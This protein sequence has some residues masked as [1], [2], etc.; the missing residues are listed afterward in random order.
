MY[1]IIY[2][3]MNAL[4]QTGV[5][6]GSENPQKGESEFQ[7]ALGR[8]LAQLTAPDGWVWQHSGS[9]EKERRFKTDALSNEDTIAIDIFGENHLA[10]NS[11]AIELKYVPAPPK[12]KY[13]FPWDVAKD[14]LKLDLL[15]SGSCKPALT[16]KLQTYVLAMTNWQKYWSSAGKFGWASNFMNVMRS[17]P[18]CF[19][20][21]IKT[22][23]RNPDNAIFKQ[24][25][26]HIA[27]GRNWSGEWRT[28]GSVGR[29]EEWRYLLLRPELDVQP[30]WK[31]HNEE[32]LDQQSRIIPFLNRESRSEWA[33]RR[34]QFM[35]P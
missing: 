5:I 11:V 4:G 35:S 3:A 20:G 28:Y 31:H 33:A 13:A 14:C 22:T 34:K 26:C 19:R 29:A 15:Q 32:C 10:G 21:L 16:S 7:S 18:V 25:R 27:L 6:F 24:K 30:Q 23:S 8:K 2:E 9:P 17:E 12:D 1:K